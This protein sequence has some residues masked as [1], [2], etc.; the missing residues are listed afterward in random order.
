MEYLSGSHDMQRRK[1]Q[2]A[3]V[4]QGVQSED[5]HLDSAGN[6][7]ADGTAASES[8]GRD[9]AGGA[10]PALT[11]DTPMPASKRRHNPFVKSSRKVG[12]RLQRIQR[13]AVFLLQATFITQQP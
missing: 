3:S 6:Q 4:S 12:S 11:F 8:A 5:A 13:S 1:C 10:A 7:P 2:F 9:V